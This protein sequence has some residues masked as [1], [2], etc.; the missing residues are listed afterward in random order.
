MPCMIQGCT[1][2]RMPVLLEK[3]T[4]RSVYLLLLLLLLLQNLAG[5]QDFILLSISLY[6]DLDDPVFDGVGLAS[7]KSRNP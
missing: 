5:A 7:F 2:R 6:K 1:N 4:Q 3:F